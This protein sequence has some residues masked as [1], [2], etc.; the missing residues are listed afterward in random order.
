M[1][2]HSLLWLIAMIL[3]L[4]FA[5][6][7]VSAEKYQACYDKELMSALR[8]Y[9]K[10][11]TLQ[12]ANRGKGFY[13]MIMGD[14]GVDGALRKHFAKPTTP[15]IDVAPGV[16]MPSKLAEYVQSF[17]GY[18]QNFMI[19]IELLC[20]R[21]A[22]ALHWLFYL[23]PF[24][25]AIVFDGIMVRKAKIASFRYTSPTVYNL[26]WHAIIGILAF[27]LVYFTLHFPISVFYYPTALSVMGLLLRVVIGNIQHSA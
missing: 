10:D 13:S 25:A 17:M 22:H 16:K 20:H 14:T 11:E 7:L 1:R 8:W 27:S 18:W 26:S 6:L 3:I 19:N 5:P 4:L 21:L 15:D 9:G 23:L 2:Q 12:I 24:M